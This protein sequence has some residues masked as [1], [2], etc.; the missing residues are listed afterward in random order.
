[1]IRK[2][3]EGKVSLLPRLALT[4]PVTVT[5]SLIALMVVG[6]IAYKS[7]AVEL[8][9]A[10]F[11]PPFLGV[12]TPYPNANPEEV[13]QLIARPIEEMVRTIKG[14]QKVNTNSRANGCWTFLRFNQSTDM[15][16]AYAQLR[17]RIDRVKPELPDDVER[18]Y[19]RKWNNDDDAIMWIVMIPDKPIRDPYY[20]T[21]THIKKPLERVDGVANVEI[22]GA[23][24]KSIQIQIDQDAI[25]RFKINLYD[26]IQKLRQDNFA[27]SSGNLRDGGQK[28]YVR[29]VGKFRSID[30]VRHIPV[31]GTN[32]LLKD[33]AKVVYDVPEKTWV[34][35]LNGKR[36]I[37]IG[38]YKESMANTVAL[39]QKVKDIF[40]NDFKKDPQLAQFDVEILFSQGDYILE[41]ID[42]LKSAGLWGGFFAFIVL[43]FF[44][45]RFR[46][47]MMLNLAIPLS[48]LV[49]LTVLYFIGW[50]LNLITMMGLM[51]SIGMVV[52]NSIVVLENIYRK[53]SEGLTNEQAAAEGTSEVS[54]A[55]TMATFTTIVVFLPLILMNDNMGFQFYMLRIGVPVIVSLLAS[56]LVAMVFIPLVATRI[57]SR[58][59]VHEP[60]II[61]KATERYAS[62]LQWTL[63]HR[64]ETFIVLMAVF[65]SMFYAQGNVA[66]T[67]NMEG[68]IN[69]F[70]I[71]LDLPDNYTLDDAERVVSMVEDSIRAKAEKYRVRAIDV[72]YRKTMARFNVYLKKEK[73]VS[74]Y[75][76]LWNGSMN[77]LGMK[78]TTYMERDAVV[79]D[80]KKRIPELPGITVRTSW[81]RSSSGDDA[82]VTINLFGDDTRKLAGLSREV[83]RRLRSIPEIISVETDRE[84]G[85]DEI[86]LE[87]KRE[88]AKAF[89]IPI[90]TIT[91][92][93][94]YMLR[95]I[96][97]PKFQTDDREIDMRIQ[98]REE[99]RENLQ[100]LK[101][102]TFFSQNGKE[103]PLATLV[104][105]K[106]TK[107]FG[108]ISRENGKTYLAV[109]ASSTSEN[110]SKIH[111]KIDRAMEGFEMPYG[112]KW[113]KGARFNSIM[114]RNQSQMFGVW[115]AIIFVYLLM[116]ILFESF[117]L[118][119]SVIVSIPF[120]FVGAYWMLYITNTPFDMM[121][122]IGL[123]I[124]IGIVVNN[125]IVLIDTVNRLREDGLA[126]IDA[127]VQAGKKRLRPIL[128]TAFT[129]IGGLIPMA[130]GNAKM[131]GIS[132]KP[133][134]L[135]IIG[136]LMFSTLVSLV[137]VPYAYMLFDDMRVYFK[138]LVAGTL[139][140][141]GAA[142]KAADAH[143]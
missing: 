116:G 66:Q 45:R 9:P 100:Q 124:L 37:Q 58:K 79:E 86:H 15:D 61:H 72:R 36:A 105:I 16:L 128:M 95:G 76:A 4:R 30:D 47:T 133:M 83:E 27:I 49:S 102:I 54:L 51:I 13:E 143:G 113:S 90:R 64:M 75:Q 125:A 135:T 84:K 62:L 11:T 32:I 136:G 56:L 71:F 122:S 82:S 53:R 23:D 19:I 88:Q 1:M 26:V 43:Y 25:K 112:Y 126:R 12:W 141:G 97:L 142:E 59:K 46:M 50:S 111:A 68:N 123:I 121:S 70:R 137:A 42:N 77:L 138:K 103:V 132:Y 87:I 104:N 129:T 115:L 3:L 2:K 110:L 92:T 34:Q 41:S 55:V 6:F 93:I 31:K 106:I 17:D 28:I 35:R 38:I 29:S 7:I 109:K 140:S 33:V 108:A 52:D 74:W 67:D 120:S 134:G 24:E 89:G 101:N 48:I 96:Q 8:M 44:L 99:D 39:T 131:I 57:V 80:V 14:L 73:P 130:L 69:N 21:E 63:N 127:L 20:F 60:A 10:G 18:L 118:P 117:I 85:M 114:E 78:D 81:R 98:L 40:N 119:L 22:V 65:I 139:V 91:G 94:M 107:G 5:M